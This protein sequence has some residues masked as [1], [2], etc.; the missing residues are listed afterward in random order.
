MAKRRFKPEDNKT[1][2]ALTPEE[3][4]ERRKKERAS[5]GEAK[6]R[7]R[8]RMSPARRAVIVAVP[9]GVIVAVVVILLFFNP[10][11]PP[12]ITFAPI[13]SQSGPPTFPLHNTTDFSTSWCPQGGVATVFQMYPLL[14]VYVNGASV[15]LP[16]GIGHNSSYPAGVACNLPIRTNASD[17]AAGYPAGTIRI[18]SAWAYEYSLGDFF[19]VWRQSFSSAFINSTYPSQQIVYTSTDLLGFTADASHSVTLSIDG[20]PSTAGPNL[21]LNY[22]DFGP[23]PY[24]SCIASRFGSGHTITLSYHT[25]AAGAAVAQSPARSV[26]SSPSGGPAAS[27]PGSFG[28]P[29]LTQVDSLSHGSLRWLAMRPVG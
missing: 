11:L 9:S 14:K 3:R 4:R 1:P 13:P 6:R 5:G 28:S 23:N 8:G 16:N 29:T 27:I 24:P 26:G 15:T 20:S 10:F 19:N 12:C 17:A 21:T 22:L 2:E 7:E 18:S 25:H